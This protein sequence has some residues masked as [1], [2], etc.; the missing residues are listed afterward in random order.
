MSGQ[1]GSDAHVYGAVLLTRDFDRKRWP[2]RPY[3][4]VVGQR[5]PDGTGKQERLTRYRSGCSSSRCPYV[6]E[7]L[8]SRGAES[9]EVA[10]TL[11]RAQPTIRF[12]AYDV[13]VMLVLPVVFAAAHGTDVVR[14]VLRQSH[15]SSSTVAF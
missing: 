6:I 5:G 11:D 1:C 15:S 4:I 9:G 13:G 2:A 14:A 3:R 8:L 10:A 7:T 12:A